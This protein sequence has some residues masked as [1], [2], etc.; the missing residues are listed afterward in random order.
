MAPVVS[1]PVTANVFEDDPAST[2]DPLANAS[3]VDNPVL[4]LRDVPID[5]PDGVS[6]NGRGAVTPPAG[7]TFTN[8]DHITLTGAQIEVGIDTTDNPDVTGGNAGT[9]IPFAPSGN[10]WAGTF[11]SAN[12]HDGDVGT[13]VVSDGTYAILNDTGPQ[14]TLD[15][16]GSVTIGSIAIYNGYV[17]RDDGTYTLRDGDTGDILGQ[18]TITTPDHPTLGGINEGAHSF[19]LTFNTPITTDSLI[20]ETNI[21]AA[22]ENTASFREIQVFAALPR[23]PRR[24][25][26]SIRQIRRSNTL[27]QAR[28]RSLL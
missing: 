24:C 14:A 25:S 8:S 13:G 20:L 9:L 27:L 17:N 10:F 18:W 28:P 26:Q 4:S 22:D 21:T 16:G 1:G 2:L 19:W 15:F 7:L 23:R 6:F 5:L 11:G 12:L 3:D